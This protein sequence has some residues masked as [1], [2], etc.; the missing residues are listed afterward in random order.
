[1]I[2]SRSSYP[3]PVSFYFLLLSQVFGNEIWE[4]IKQS[5]FLKSAAPLSSKSKFTPAMEP[6]FEKRVI[7][8]FEMNQ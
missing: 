7:T 3:N 6:H 5:H 2:H 1:M 4:E 8:S